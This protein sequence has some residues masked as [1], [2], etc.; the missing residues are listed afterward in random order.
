[1]M[2]FQ[3]ITVCVGDVKAGWAE[4]NCEECEGVFCEF[5]LE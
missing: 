3:T 5:D 1:M 4:L 2:L